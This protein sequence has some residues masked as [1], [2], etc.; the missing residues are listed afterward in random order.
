MKRKRSAAR[1]QRTKL[2]SSLPDGWHVN[3]DRPIPGLLERR[4]DVFWFGVNSS[5][6]CSMEL[7]IAS[8]FFFFSFFLTF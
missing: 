4:V 2:L 5:L 7:E 6:A 8:C 3:K 1:W